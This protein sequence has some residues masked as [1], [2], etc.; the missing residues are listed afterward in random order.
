MV[1]DRQNNNRLELRRIDRFEVV[2]LYVHLGSLI[3]NNG[4]IELEI[5]RCE[6]SKIAM[7][8]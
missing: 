4:T 7:K 1:I 6:M 5:R 3:T 2:D 8:N